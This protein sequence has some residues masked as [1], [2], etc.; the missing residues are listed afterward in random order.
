MMDRLTDGHKTV[1]MCIS[2][3]ECFRYNRLSAYEDTGLMPEDVEELQKVVRL[4]ESDRDGERE[5]ADELRTE[6]SRLMAD[7]E[8]IVR[9]INSTRACKMCVHQEYAPIDGPCA[10]CNRAYKPHFEWARPCAENGGA[11]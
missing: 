11:K 6:N 2:P 9:Q 1:S 8:A 5:D 4:L 7:L 10:K 3:D